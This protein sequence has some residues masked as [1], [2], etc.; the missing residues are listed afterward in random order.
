VRH[1]DSGEYS[2]YCAISEGHAHV[3]VLA[4]LDLCDGF[5]RTTAAHSREGLE[6]GALTGRIALTVYEMQEG[7]LGAF[8]G[9]LTSRMNR[10]AFGFGEAADEVGVDLR[11]RMAC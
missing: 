10:F 7:H 2:G 9:S 5:I 3:D 4:W 6:L 11:G 8:S 1:A